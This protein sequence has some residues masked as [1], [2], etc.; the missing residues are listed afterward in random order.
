LSTTKTQQKL[1]IFAAD[2]GGGE[3]GVSSHM[4]QLANKLIEKD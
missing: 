4:V 1:N 2:F 3:G